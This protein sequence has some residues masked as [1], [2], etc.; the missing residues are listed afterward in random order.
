MG[1]KVIS[2]FVLCTAFKCSSVFALGGDSTPVFEVSPKS[3]GSSD[4]QVALISGEFRSNVKAV[5]V[6]SNSQL[7]MPL[8][9]RLAVPLKVPQQGYYLKIKGFYNPKLA[10]TFREHGGSVREEVL[11]MGERDIQEI[12]EIPTFVDSLEIKIRGERDVYKCFDD[13][14]C[15]YVER[16]SASE[17]VGLLN[18]VRFRKLLSCENDE[19]VVE[20]L[21]AD[22]SKQRLRLKNFEVS[23][24]LQIEQANHGIGQNASSAS[25]FRGLSAEIGSFTQYGGAYRTLH[26]Y[27]ESGGLKIKVDTAPHYFCHYEVVVSYP[28]SFSL[29]APIGMRCPYAGDRARVTGSSPGSDFDYSRDWFFQGCQAV[30][31]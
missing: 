6:R 28:R 11:K 4:A 27:P 10:V 8:L 23:A 18:A 5:E 21:Y 15:A 24:Y 1:Q 22:S 12:L 7:M 3:D 14:T 26:A 13:E 25:E 20:S 19:A 29:A 30:A 16:Q 2:A 17:Y 9:K 31:D